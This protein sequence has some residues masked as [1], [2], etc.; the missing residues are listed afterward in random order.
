MQVTLVKKAQFHST[1]SRFPKFF[2]VIALTIQK[3][4]TTKKTKKKE[5]RK[6][7]QQPNKTRIAKQQQKTPD[8]FQIDYYRCQ[9]TALGSHLPN[10]E[11]EEQVEVLN[12]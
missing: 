4:T 3:T 2:L 9:L 7:Q 6:N 1:Q 8:C 11:D 10:V 12:C 5:K